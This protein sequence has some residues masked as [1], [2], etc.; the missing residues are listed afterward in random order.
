MT[1]FGSAAAL[2]L[3]GTGIMSLWAPEERILYRRKHISSDMLC[4]AP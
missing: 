3:F 2:A 1:L 4:D